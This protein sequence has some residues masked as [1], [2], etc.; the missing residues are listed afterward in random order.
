MIGFRG[1]L[2]HEVEQQFSINL[3]SLLCLTA[4]KAT[5]NDGFLRLWSILVS[6]AVYDRM[7][8]RDLRRE[9]TQQHLSVKLISPPFLVAYMRQLT[10]L[11]ACGFRVC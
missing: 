4:H 3:I 9:Q 2:Q 10:A 11:E 8:K 6:I 5:Y 7:Q 1:D